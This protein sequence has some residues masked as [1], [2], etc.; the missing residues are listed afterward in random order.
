MITSAHAHRQH[1]R[2]AAHTRHIRA[3]CRRP[4]AGLRSRRAQARLLLRS[5]CYPSVEQVN[6]EPQ[7]ERGAD[8][9]RHLRDFVERI[10]HLNPPAVFLPPAECVT[11][12]RQPGLPIAGC[13]INSSSRGGV[14][15]HAS[16]RAQMRGS[17]DSGLPRDGGG[18]GDTMRESRPARSVSCQAGIKPGLREANS[19]GRSRPPVNESHSTGGRFLMAEATP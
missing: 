11:A 16:V 17:S 9:Q 19:L 4:T 3:I 13:R 14:E 2:Y 15:G 5:S 6:P 10:F 18:S 8:Q 7:Q 1:D 12:A